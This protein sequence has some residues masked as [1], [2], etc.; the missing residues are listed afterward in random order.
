MTT[1]NIV[2]SY[3]N[4][5]DCEHG[6]QRGKCPECDLIECETE[7]ANILMLLK[8]KELINE[9]VGVCGHTIGTSIKQECDLCKARR[10]GITDY[11]TTI[12]NLIMLRIFK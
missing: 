2:L 9:V 10:Y 11:N 3:P 4:A 6:R 5:R 12:R 8:D 7:N 1:P